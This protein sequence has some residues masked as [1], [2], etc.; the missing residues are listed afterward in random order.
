MAS[1]ARVA[2]AQ[3][4]WCDMNERMNGAAHGRAEGLARGHGGAVYALDSW[5]PAR[6]I[7]VHSGHSHPTAPRP[8]PGPAPRTAPRTTPRTPPRT[9]QPAPNPALHPTPHP[10]PHNAPP[11]TPQRNPPPGTDRHGQ[12]LPLRTRGTT[13]ILKCCGV[14][15]SAPLSYE[16]R[17][18]PSDGASRTDSQSDTR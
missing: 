1:E 3:L 18:G 13:L 7:C 4:W 17:G 12:C 6:V 14:R 2:S 16:L 11:R 10:A 9:P 15:E 8:A 5:C